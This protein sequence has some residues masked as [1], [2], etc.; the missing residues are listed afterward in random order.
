[1]GQPLGSFA[2]GSNQKQV[3]LRGALPQKRPMPFQ[4]RGR[5]RPKGDLKPKE[6]QLPK[7]AGQRT[8]MEAQTSGV[9]SV[10][11]KPSEIPSMQEPEFSRLSATSLLCS[12]KYCVSE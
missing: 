6:P 9:L 5:D 4:D 11:R 7:S 3:E 2:S 10:F 1:M 8:A 12:L